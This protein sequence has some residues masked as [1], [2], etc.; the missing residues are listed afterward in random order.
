[1]LEL[2]EPIEDNMLQYLHGKAYLFEYSDQGNAWVDAGHATS[3]YEGDAFGYSL[4]VS[5]DGGRVLVSAP[6]R[7]VENELNVG[8]A[9]VFGDE[10]VL[11]K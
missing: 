9:Q 1:M 11:N 8:I 4:A 6:F 10:D 2:D 7:I 3:T 5:G